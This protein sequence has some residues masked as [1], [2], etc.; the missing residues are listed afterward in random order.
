MYRG[1]FMRNKK[2][3]QWI[4]L[5]FAVT[6]VL[7]FRLFHNTRLYGHDTLFH[8]SNIIALSKTISINNIQGDQ[9][10]SSF[11]NSFGYGTWLFYPKLP[12]LLGAYI[13]LVCHNVYLSM[14]C[15]YFITTFLSGIVVFYL[16]YKIFK[17]D[18]VAFLSSIFYLTCSYHICEI[19]IRD[20]YAE[21]FMF[22]VI[23]L[24]FLGLLELKENH[25]LKFY[26]F[27]ISG[28]V[29]G[30]YSH[31][32]SMVFCTI[33]VAL[34][35]IY[36]HKCFLNF[37][38]IKKLL[39]SAMI[40]TCLVL[41]FLTTI[42]EH[43]MLRN[44]VVFTE[45]F[46]NRLSTVH[47]ILPFKSY[48]NHDKNCNYNNIL[49]YF[50]YSMIVLF[51]LTT[52]VSFEKKNRQKYLEEKKLFLFSILILIAFINS[53]W[54]WEKIPDI[55]IM[56]QFPWRL[57]TVMCLVISLYTPMFLLYIS[58]LK[59]VKIKKCFFI[60]LVIV[61]IGE[62]LNNIYYYGDHIYSTKEL[63]ESKNAMGWQLE[64]LP[65]KMID[66]SNFHYGD[67]L[68]ERE[69]KIIASTTDSFVNV[70]I[71]P[72]VKFGF[73]YQNN[74]RNLIDL[75]RNNNQFKIKTSSVQFQSFTSIL[76]DNFPALE[77]QVTNVNC[78]TYLEIPRVYYLGYQLL[79]EDG[80]LIKLYETDHGLLGAEITESGIYTLKYVG[81]IITKISRFIRLFTCVIV[82]AIGG[83][84][85]WKK[86]K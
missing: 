68:D 35:L 42:L 66:Q 71:I 40:V 46:S 22:L 32:V 26:L 57:M 72:D 17:Q 63:V 44:Y 85:L 18:K 34:F 11:A 33:F 73:R 76:K 45:Y 77:F 12:H 20:A 19:Y 5:M 55:F 3:L 7:L 9:I 83:Y 64:Y 43:I 28:Y 56:I 39:I 75:E 61:M 81:S 59:Y 74:I 69:Y 41:P 62:G 6:L 27:F 79:N 2:N 37:K 21:N 60:I 65:V 86:K 51:I 15:V 38:K 80:E 31:L 78:V 29:I 4:L 58:Q 82:L 67:Y 84:S 36:Y 50:N 54:L 14:N 53:K 49:V 23:P 16:A 13:Y 70:P 52:I 30:M 48:F 47:N 25:N 10:I 1:S 24:V 8:T